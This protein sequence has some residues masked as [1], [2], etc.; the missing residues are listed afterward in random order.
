MRDSCEQLERLVETHKDS[1]DG[2]GIFAR[3]TLRAARS[4]QSFEWKA[5]R[6][7][8]FHITPEG[9]FME[10]VKNVEVVIRRSA[11]DEKRKQEWLAAGDDQEQ[12]DE[13]VV[14]PPGQRRD[15][16]G[17]DLDK[18]NSPGGKKPNDWNVAV[19]IAGW[20]AVDEMRTLLELHY[21]ARGKQR[22]VCVVLS[23]LLYYTFPR[24]TSTSRSTELWASKPGSETASIRSSSPP[25]NPID[26]NCASGFSFRRA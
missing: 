18:S 6:A 19:K 14:P 2:L 4:I 8:R 9:L 13:N 5:I 21:A 17:L 3:E 1:H 24:T 12:P 20:V 16:F 25:R 22:D 15:I 7:E 11:A 10:L 26:E 23:V